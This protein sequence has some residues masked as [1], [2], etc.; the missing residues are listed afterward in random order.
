MIT[1][2]SA[3]LCAHVFV[4]LFNVA[5]TA[6]GHGVG[7]HLSSRGRRWRLAVDR[8]SDVGRCLSVVGCL[9]FRLPDCGVAANE[10]SSGLSK[11]ADERGVNGGNHGAS[12]RTVMDFS[13]LDNSLFVSTF[14]QAEQVFLSSF[15]RTRTRTLVIIIVSS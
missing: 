6:G 11:I 1:N 12:L 5:R 8:Q 15:L 13:N 4:S 3:C 9:V 14:G 10:S 2:W 7:V